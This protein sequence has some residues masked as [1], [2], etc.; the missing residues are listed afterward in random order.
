MHGY[1][2]SIRLFTGGRYGMLDAHELV[3]LHL[4]PRIPVAEALALCAACN[5]LRKQKR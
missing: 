2:F 1:H 5:G 4:T 3:A